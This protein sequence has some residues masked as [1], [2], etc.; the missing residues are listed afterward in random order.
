[1]GRKKQLPLL[2][3]I[4]ITDIAAEGKAIARTDNR[5]VFV[6][7]AVPGDVVDIQVRKKR[8]GF[9]EGQVV[10]MHEQSEI[11]Q[12]PVCEHFGVCGGCKWQMLPYAEQLKFKEKQVRDQLSRIGHIQDPPVQAIMGAKESEYYRNKLEFTFSNKRWLTHEEISSQDGI[13]NR[14]ALGFHV[15][16]L[17]D[18]VVDIKK[19]FL[20]QDPSNAI[21]IAVSDFA[22]NNGLS[23][24]DLRE[25]TGMLRNLII[26]TASTGEV[27]VIVAF[28]ENDQARRE[29]LMNH[30]HT[31]FPEITSLNYVINQKR[32]DT[33]LDQDI[34]CFAG[35]DHIREEME[36]LSFKIG[37]KSFYQ[38][39]SDQAY[40]LYKVAREFAD[41]SGEEIVYDLYTGTGTI[42]NFLASK[43][44]RVIGIETVP[45]AIGDARLNAENNGIS[46]TD[47]VVGDMKDVFNESLFNK[48][49]LPDVVVL[50]P[51][52]AGIHQNVV[53]VLIKARP[54]RIVYVSCNPATQARDISL[55]SQFYYV[56]KVQPV[57][58]F[59]HT[60]HVENVALLTHKKSQI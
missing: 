3:R 43:A 5:V 42:A 48:Y 46:N 8:K 17:F 7:M 26:R 31:A 13:E 28:F 39:N 10:K 53:D 11:R 20:Q 29:M 52:R 36:G 15:P 60:H 49:G 44:K 57:D 24:F 27:M 37:P 40:E 12:E 54:K 6:A 58:M 25:Q 47:F 1:V 50:D 59:P 9:F 4:T 16:G 22:Q 56:E 34:I 55:M 41:L 33:I 18:K 19:C 2:E 21:R 23:F 51:P 30:L 35:S 14:N 32:N 38:T 45:E